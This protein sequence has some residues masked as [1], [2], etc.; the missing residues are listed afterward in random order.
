M[1]FRWVVFITLWTLLSGPAFHV[2][3]SAFSHEPPAHVRTN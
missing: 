2:P 3:T 1:D